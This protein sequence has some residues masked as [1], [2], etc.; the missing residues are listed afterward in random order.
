M[1]RNVFFKCLPIAFC[2][3]CG[4]L[5]SQINN[6]DFKRFTVD[7][8]KQYYKSARSK[9]FYLQFKDERDETERMGY[10]YSDHDI[11]YF[12]FPEE[13]TAYLTSKCNEADPV[14][15]KDTLI[16]GIRRL[17]VSQE[18][19]SSS[20]AKAILL[21]P[22]TTKGFCRIIC[23]VY[24]KNDEGY[25]LLYQYDSTITKNGYLGN[26]NDELIG[27][28]LK[29]MMQTVDSIGIPASHTKTIA[30]T[31]FNSKRQRPK[32]IT[33]EKTSDG[34]YLTYTDFL[35]NKPVD[36][37]FEVIKTKK[38]RQIKLA[39]NRDDDSVYTK[40][41][42]GFCKDG[43]IYAR[44]GDNFSELRRQQNSFDLFIAEPVNAKFRRYA[45]TFW[46][47]VSIATQVGAPAGM[48]FALTEVVLPD[49]MAPFSIEK[50][51][52]YTGVY[53]LD[54]ETGEIY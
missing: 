25:L 23:N 16:L 52:M 22:V 28:S 46:R 21:T 14:L 53:K 10:F 30:A 27:N 18:K 34:I 2:I 24:K 1:V 8:K 31:D 43:V 45:N 11:Y 15:K 7:F 12:T 9:K 33:D 20:L 42:W 32:I 49:V 4:K 39:E 47:G 41:S 44:I 26:T 50:A 13:T 51:M 29:D 3:L 6:A 54:M 36:I 17:W 37:H 40:S 35:N 19:I 5:F 48:L 38:I